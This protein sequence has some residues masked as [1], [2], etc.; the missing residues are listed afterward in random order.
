MIFIPHLFLYIY[1][2]WHI[3]TL[4]I[5]DW[6]VNVKMYQEW[7]IVLRTFICY[8]ICGY[9]LIIHSSSLPWLYP[10]S[11]CVCEP[12]SYYLKPF[13]AESLNDTKIFWNSQGSLRQKYMHI[14][15]TQMTP[16]FLVKFDLWMPLNFLSKPR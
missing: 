3:K 2:I 5:S 10:D 1:I 16:L 12:L 8:A 6:K 15:I 4:W 7:T 14:Q 11:F 9:Q 13:K